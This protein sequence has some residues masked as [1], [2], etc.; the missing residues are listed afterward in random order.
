MG[1]G[2]KYAFT[3]IALLSILDEGY[4]V[5]EEPEQHQH[6]KSLEYPM[7]YLYWKLSKNSRIQVFLSTQSIELIDYVLKA[8]RKYKVDAKIFK[9]YLKDGR[10]IYVTYTPGKAYESRKEIEADL[11]Y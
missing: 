6:L 3:Y 4:L 9:I 5:I 1:D 11:G 8:R 10:I 7:K 2:F